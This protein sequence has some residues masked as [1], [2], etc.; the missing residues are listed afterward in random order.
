MRRSG[1]WSIVLAVSL[2]AASA[3]GRVEETPAV[4]TLEQLAAA[5][6]GGRSDPTCRSSGPGGEYA[7]PIRGAEHCEWPAVSRGAHSGTVT[8]TR[9]SLG[10]LRSLTWQ[11]SVPDSAT[12]A[13]LVDSLARALSAAGLTSH[14]CRGGGRRWQRTG[15]G[16]QFMPVAVE[17]DGSRRVMVFATPLPE[18]LPAL[19]CPGA[20]TAPSPD[21]GRPSA[22][23]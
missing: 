21:A 23:D 4:P 5:W 17:N 10:V 7:G 20:A 12:A 9:D 13:Q 11:R 8:G 22:S 2:C 19:L 14:P 16:V 18:A 15:L 3:C 1:P 6:S